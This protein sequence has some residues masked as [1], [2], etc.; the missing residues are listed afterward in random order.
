MSVAIFAKMVRLSREL[1]GPAAPISLSEMLPDPD[2][3]WLPDVEGQRYTSELRMVAL[4]QVK[5]FG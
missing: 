5:A 2:H 1:G 4:D 3:L